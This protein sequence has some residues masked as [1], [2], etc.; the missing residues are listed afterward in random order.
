MALTDKKYSAIHSKTGSDKDK[1]KNVFDEGHTA[2]FADNP[3]DIPIISALMYQIQEIQEELD[4]LRTEISANKDKTGISNSQASAITANTA[5]TGITTKQATAI[6]SNSNNID[7]KMTVIPNQDYTGVQY[8][9]AG[10]VLNKDKSYS[11]VFT[12][13]EVTPR[14]TTTKTGLIQLK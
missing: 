3:E 12:Y 7:A 4:Y 5:K 13:A 14:G 8:V 1:I 11:L 6:T 9:R 2:H 10:V